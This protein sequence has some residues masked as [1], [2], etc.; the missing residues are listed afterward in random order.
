MKT[1]LIL[2]LIIIIGIV[3]INTSSLKKN[4][5]F[6]NEPSY[7][8]KTYVINLDKDKNRFN[9]ISTQLKE[10]QID[11][12]RFPAINGAKLD[13]NKLIKDGTVVMENGSFFNHNTEG[14]NSLHGSIGCALSHINLWKHILNENENENE[15][16]LILEDDCIIPETFSQDLNTRI[17]EV[18][19]NWDIIFCG[20]SRLNIKK[21]P[22]TKY[23]Y[24]PTKTNGWFNC[25]TFAYIINKKSIPKLLKI[26]DPIRTYIDIQLNSHYGNDLDVY[27]FNPMLIQHNYKLPSSRLEFSKNTYN[28]YFT[29]FANN[30]IM[31]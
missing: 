12:T 26:C 18:P 15:N 19:K 27:Y 2:F 5:G 28:K 14:R 6:Y 11:F 20:G 30:I 9:L 29:Y 25:G 23:I 10:A 16:I 3:L 7:I 17:K 1:Y 13:V 22:N 24:T 31:N 4:E 21:V 8:N